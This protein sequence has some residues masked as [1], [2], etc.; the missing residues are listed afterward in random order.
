MSPATA[1]PKLMLA[2]SR[3]IES[4]GCTCTSTAAPCEAEAEL[5]V[6]VVVVVEV[7]VAVHEVDDAD[8]FLGAGGAV[9]KSAALSSLSM[10]PPFARASAVVLLGAAAAPVPS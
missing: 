9:A 1:A 5:V 4:T 7:V 2:R 3:A 8:E 10:K 6:V